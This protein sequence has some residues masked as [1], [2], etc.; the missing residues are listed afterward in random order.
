MD[1]YTFGNFTNTT[2]NPI[3]FDADVVRNRKKQ[4]K[5]KKGETDNVIIDIAG[6]VQFFLV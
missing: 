5:A 3:C 2:E 4:M 6:I 1:K